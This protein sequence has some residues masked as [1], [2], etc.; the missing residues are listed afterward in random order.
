MATRLSAL[1]VLEELLNSDAMD[2]LV[3]YRLQQ[4]LENCMENLE[5]LYAKGVDNL[6]PYQHTDYV[7]NLQF[8]RSLVSV[9]ESYSIDDYMDDVIKLNRYA[10]E[11]E[12]M[13]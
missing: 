5:S 7:D 11:I 1:D 9:L 8:A 10:S 12:S 6:K 3:C 2:D 13:Y 4:S